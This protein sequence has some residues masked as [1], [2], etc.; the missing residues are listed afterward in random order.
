[1]SLF[2]AEESA[3]EQGIR[4]SFRISVNDPSDIA[5]FTRAEH[6]P[7]V[8]ASP[9]LASPPHPDPNPLASASFSKVPSPLPTS[10]V[11]PPRVSGQD[12][13]FS[14]SDDTAR[15]VVGRVIPPSSTSGDLSP[16]EPHF[17]VASEVINPVEEEDE[18]MPS[19]D[20]GSDSD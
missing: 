10:R 12:I 13:R 1:V 8:Q 16:S 9:A 14:E 7:T 19:I 4:E 17:G 15:P 5:G 11:S 2:R 6:Q 3:E 18:E 20:M